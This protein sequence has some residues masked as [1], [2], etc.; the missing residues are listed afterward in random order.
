[1]VV[2]IYGADQYDGGTRRRLMYYEFTNGFYLPALAKPAFDE[3]FARLDHVQPTFSDRLVK[4][5]G[6][7]LVPEALDALVEWLIYSTTNRLPRDS[8]I[9]AY[10]REMLGGLADG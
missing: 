7:K 4:H 10:R 6:I 9:L 2:P 8:L 3:G 5:R 1:M